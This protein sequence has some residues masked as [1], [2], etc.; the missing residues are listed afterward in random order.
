MT[1]IDIEWRHLVVAEATCDRCGDTG[2]L[3]RQ[4]V[5]EL[6]HECA[7]HQVNIRLT[8]TPLGPERIAESNMVL[9][10]GRPLE[11]IVPTI[12][13][14]S[15]SCVSCGDLTGRDEQCRTL[16]ISGQTF[17]VPPVY[18]IRAEVCRLAGCC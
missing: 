8:E 3:L 1:T 11:A 2:A 12:Q 6:N 17:E 10:N 14:G 4:L 7:P 15:S 18:L 5:A 13:V 9:I 16:E